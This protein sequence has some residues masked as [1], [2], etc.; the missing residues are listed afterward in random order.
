MSSYF[1][2]YSSGLDYNDS[3]DGAGGV[4]EQI[5]P[6]RKQRNKGSG[7]LSLHETKKVEIQ[8]I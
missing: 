4:E 7:L 1:Y 5:H 6:K 8:R 3:S 2:I